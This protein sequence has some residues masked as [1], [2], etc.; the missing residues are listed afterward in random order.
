MT[1]HVKQSEA[2]RGAELDERSAGRVLEAHDAPTEA[3]SPA[4]ENEPM[5]RR[6]GR[7]IG[8]LLGLAALIAALVFVY[9]RPSGE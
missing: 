1:R 9:A 6:K 7:S 4:D 3:R 5:I 2:M 8:W